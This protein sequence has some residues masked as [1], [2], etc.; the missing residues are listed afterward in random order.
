[1]NK[2]VGRINKILKK[3]IGIVII[4]IAVLLVCH[5]ENVYA[6]TPNEV[7]KL[8]KDNQVVDQFCGVKSVYILSSSDTGMYSCAG[9]VK[10]FYAALYGVNVYSINTYN[11]PPMVSS[12]TDKVALIQVSK[13]QPGDIMQNKERGHVAIVKS[14]SGNTVTLIEQNWKWSNGYEKSCRIN[15]TITV[16]SSYFYRLVINGK[17]VQAASSKVNVPP[18]D[19]EVWQMM[20][21]GGVNLRKGRLSSS[22]L[23]KVIPY[24]KIVKVVAKKKDASGSVWAKTTYEGKTGWFMTVFASYAWGKIKATVKDTTPPVISNIKITDLSVNGYTVSCTVT[25]NIGVSRVQFPTW[26]TNDGQDDITPNWETATACSGSVSGSTYTFKVRRIEHGNEFGVYNTHIYAY[27]AKGNRAGAIAELVELGIPEL[28]KD[29]YSYIKNEKSGKFV[30]FD[31]SE[32][33]ACVEKYTGYEGQLW[34]FSK[35]KNGYYTIS[36]VKT[37]K[38]LGISKASDGKTLCV[39]L[40]TP[41]NSN[42]QMWRVYGVDGKYVITSAVSTYVMSLKNDKTFSGNKLIMSSQSKSSTCDIRL[43]TVEK[44]D[45]ITFSS[46]K[47]MAYN[48]VELKWNTTDDC[49]GYMIYKMNSETGKFQRIKKINDS[50][51]DSFIV[52]VT[53]GEKSQ[54]V[55]K[56]FRADK[57]GYKYSVYSNIVDITTKLDKPEKAEVAAAE[58]GNVVSWSKVAGAQGFEIY[59]S[60]NGGAYKKIGTTSKLRKLV[61]KQYSTTENLKYKVRAFRELGGKKIRSEYKVVAF[62]KESL[63]IGD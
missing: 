7:V 1:M 48:K 57:G 29:F 60:V 58:N 30:T 19:H 32:K 35:K 33:Y 56:T 18:T 26:T 50:K 12:D 54:F 25:D 5:K 14:V 45:A 31:K 27:D 49:S 10:K 43:E 36:N 53:C 52:G 24:G 8:T 51:V 3:T 38:R 28:D 22:Q 23:L 11:G 62:A 42:S 20:S 44:L 15:R 13:P 41:K 21:A 16:S 39:K 59:R 2:Y 6:G 9:Y 37:G 63:G 47:Q 55:M 4:F 17:E 40:M 46:V 34:K 61:D